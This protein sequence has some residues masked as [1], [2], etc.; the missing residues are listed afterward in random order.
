M[1]IQALQHPPLPTAPT[2]SMLPRAHLISKT[3]AT[4]PCFV[5][6]IPFRARSSLQ[7]PI[8]P[9]S[10]RSVSTSRLPPFASLTEDFLAGPQTPPR[11]RPLFQVILFSSLTGLLWY[12]WYKF[13][14]EQ[15]LRCTMNE[16]PGGYVALCPF[17]LGVLSPLFLPNGGPAE[18]GVAFGILWIVAIQYWLYH[19]INAMCEERGLGKPLVPAWIG[20]P[21]FNL[22]VGLRSVHFLSVCFGARAGTDPVAKRLPFLGV[23]TLGVWEM[24]TNPEL[25]VKL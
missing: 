20:V 25:W 18:M 8:H 23:R 14:I 6:I 17:A 12:G 1:F 3:S 4:E 11:P 13:C 19:R 5:T 15:E 2:F 7:T 16:G 10:L 21:G 22:I 24:V 9:L